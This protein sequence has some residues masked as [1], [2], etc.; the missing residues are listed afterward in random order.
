MI[1]VDPDLLSWVHLLTAGEGDGVVAGGEAGELPGGDVHH[2]VTSMW[3]V[4]VVVVR[5]EGGVGDGG[6]VCGPVVLV[7]TGHD[8]RQVPDLGYCRSEA[9]LYS[10]HFLLHLSFLILNLILHFKKL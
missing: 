5:E 7:S 4:M 8:V 1:D 9:L 6:I 2:T 3:L 10:G